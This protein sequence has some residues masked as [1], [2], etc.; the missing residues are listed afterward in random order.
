MN[1]FLDNFALTYPFSFHRNWKKRRAKRKRRDKSLRKNEGKG[2]GNVIAREESESGN[3]KKSAR[4][5]KKENAIET[6]TKRE[7]ETEIVIERESVKR[8]ETVGETIARIG[9]DQGRKV[10]TEIE[11]GN[12]SGNEKGKETEKKRKKGT[13]RKMKKKL[14]SDGNSKENCVKRRLRTKSVLKIG[15][16][17]R[18]K[19][20]ETMKRKLSERKK[21]A[22]IWQ[23]KQND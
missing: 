1:V 14:M 22:E 11:R 8:R 16:S 6:E 7:K 15:R 13:E 21:N 5:R 9:V 20:L 3:E 23:K 12:V 10:E 4:R 19:K 18:G 2:I 17:E